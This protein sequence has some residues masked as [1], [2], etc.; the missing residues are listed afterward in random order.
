MLKYAV[1]N[2]SDGV[3]VHLNDSEKVWTVPFGFQIVP[4]GVMALGLLTVKV[5]TSHIFWIIPI[6]L[7][8][9]FLLAGRNHLVGSHLVVVMKR[10]W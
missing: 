8:L 1:T 3:S 10:H 2:I 5:C 9:T 4:A 6:V 7:N